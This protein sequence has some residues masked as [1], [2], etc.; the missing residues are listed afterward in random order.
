MHG[1]QE[2]CG[3]PHF[4]PYTPFP[5]QPCHTLLYPALPFLTLSCLDIRYRSYNYSI[6]YHTIPYHTV[7]YHTI[8]Y[9]IPYR[10]IPRC[11]IPYHTILYHTLH[12]QPSTLIH[13]PHPPDPSPLTPSPKPQTRYRGTSLIRKRPLPQDHHRTLGIGLRKGPRGGVFSCK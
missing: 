12:P 5:T 3:T 13:R 1:D 9:Y 6:L 11:T 10:I 7:P 2:G 8:T 4:L